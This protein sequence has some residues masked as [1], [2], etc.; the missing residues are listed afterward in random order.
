M[1]GTGGRETGM[2]LVSSVHGK[3]PQP[4]RGQQENGYHAASARGPRRCKTD[5]ENLHHRRTSTTPAL[6]KPP[7]PADECWW[8]WQPHL[9]RKTWSLSGLWG[10]HAPLHWNMFPGSDWWF[11]LSNRRGPPP[12]TSYG[13]VLGGGV[14]VYRFEVRD[15]TPHGG[16]VGE[17]LRIPVHG[18]IAD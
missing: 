18:I 3:L 15:S 2:N 9:P 12:S 16:A 13:T 5:W 6:P 10:Q 7:I 11:P 8:K 14:W 4:R 1:A 17:T